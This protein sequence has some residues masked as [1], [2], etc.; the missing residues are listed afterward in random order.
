MYNNLL[1]LIKGRDIQLKAVISTALAS[2]VL[3]LSAILLHWHLWAIALATIF[4]WIPLF[5]MKVLYNSRHYGFMAF[6]MVLMLVQ[7]GHVG[8]HVF[9]MA[10]YA[11][12]HEHLYVGNFE[13]DKNPDA[14][15]TIVSAGTHPDIGL[16]AGTA[17]G[18]PWGQRAVHRGSHRRAD[19]G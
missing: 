16:T 9:Q 8:E 18:S 7:A 6:H 11:A 3:Q 13:I 15:T 10:E 12:Y 14:K 1:R 19:Q 5:T 4:P 17:C 2:Y